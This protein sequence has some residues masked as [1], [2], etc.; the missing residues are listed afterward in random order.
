MLGGLVSWVTTGLLRATGSLAPRGTV[1]QARPT[2][3]G[4]STAP[5]EA[6]APALRV[7]RPDG[8]RGPAIFKGHPGTAVGMGARGCLWACGGVEDTP[9]CVAHGG[10][11]R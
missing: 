11:E 9:R 4:C 3:D 1:H 6:P 8:S 2:T 10:G 5:A 7:W